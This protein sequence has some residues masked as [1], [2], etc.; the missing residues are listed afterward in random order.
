MKKF[1][2]FLIAASFFIFPFTKIFSQNIT[3]EYGSSNVNRYLSG[4]GIAASYVNVPYHSLFE[5]NGD[6]T[7]EMWIYPISVAG[8]DKT[9][10][11][12]GAATNVSFLWGVFNRQ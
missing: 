9:L 5:Q 11:S 7:L 2:F 10:I 4:L 1:T 12:K 8:S 6:G 3:D